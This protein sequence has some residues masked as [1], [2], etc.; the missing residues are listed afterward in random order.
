MTVTAQ[1]VF[2]G[3]DSLRYLITGTDLDGSESVT[4]SNAQ[5]KADTLA[6]Q[7]WQIARAKDNGIGTIPAGQALTQAQARDILCADS[8]GASV[9]N[10]NAPRAKM[11][12]TPR[13]DIL[14]SCDADVDGSGK[15]I[16]AVTLSASG[17]AYLDIIDL[18][19]IGT[20]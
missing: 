18:G 16:I 6:G 7:L 9:G 8:S 10:K 19:A 20:S 11:V 14:V 2:Q 1:L 12:V 13:V 17:T 3:H 15:P 4:I 5:L